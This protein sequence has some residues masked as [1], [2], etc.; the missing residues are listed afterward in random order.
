VEVEPVTW[1]ELATGRSSW[2]EALESGRLRASG[3]RAD[4]SEHLPVLS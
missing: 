1:I 4:I 2:A 3:D